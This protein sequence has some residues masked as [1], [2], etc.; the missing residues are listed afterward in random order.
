MKKIKYILFLFSI[1]FLCPLGSKAATALT[2][3][4]Q[5]PVVGSSIY[6]QLNIDY[7]QDILISEAHYSIHYDASYLKLEEIYWTQSQGSYTLESGTIY[8]DKDHTTSPWEYGGQVVMKLSVLEVGRSK[9]DIKETAPA[10]YSDGN[11]V[12]QTM[13]GITISAVTPR[14]DTA[15]GALYVDGYALFPTFSKTT[16]NYTL[17]VPSSVTEVEVKAEKGE[18]RQT[19]SGDGIRKLEYGDNRVQVMVT[20]EDGSATTY[21][22]MITRT[23]NRTGDT[24]LKNLNVTNTDITYK[25]GEDTY[26]ATVSRS[27][28]NVLIVAQT[29]DLNATVIGT[30]SKD[31]L[32]GQNYF[33]LRVTTTGGNE[34]TYKI[35]IT[36]SETEIEQDKKSSKLH[37]LIVDNNTID[38]GENKVSFLVGVPKEKDKLEIKTTTESKTANV[39]I[40]GNENL[41]TGFN[42]I[43]IRVVETNEEET[44]YT[45]IAYKTPSTVEII[46]NLNNTSPYENKTLHY[47]AYESNNPVLT[48]EQLETLL[49]NNN[50]LF[51]NVINSYGGLLYQ[52]QLNKGKDYQLTLKKTTTSPLTYEMTLPSDID[53]TLYV[54]DTFA[55][56]V[57]KVYTFNELGDYKILTEGA[58]IENGYVHFKTNGDTSYVF[59]NAS[60]TPEESVLKKWLEKILTPFLVVL[61]IGAILLVYYHFKKKKEILNDEPL[62]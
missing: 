55:D 49:K 50:S 28:T 27:I 58:T 53:I 56:G 43:E 33:E 34:K 54:G 5:A 30:G 60:F 18:E 19:I 25:K 21:E 10:L 6:V 41:K 38:L 3:S 45:L 16:Y 29:E 14:S 17:T 61:L 52:V 42:V 39:E 15:I 35:I 12:S 40:L 23:D 1:L 13:S 20:A 46:N 57:I 51:Y 2:A 31:L 36:R 9:I 37:I 59:T 48:K 22:I 44:K 11:P 26:Y 4:T 32:L 8:I 47:N 7:G 24:S 62:Y